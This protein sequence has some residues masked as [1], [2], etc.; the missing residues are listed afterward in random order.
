MIPISTLTRRFAPPSPSE[1]GKGL[2]AVPLPLGEGGAKRRVRVEVLYGILSGLL[3]TLSLPKPDFYPLAWIALVPWLYAILREPNRRPVAIFSWVAGFVFF[4]GTFYWMTE[5]MIIYGG[6]SYISAVGI[7]LLFAVVYSF[8]FLAF[9][10]GVHLAAR[11]FGPRGL[12]VAA[13]LWVTI[14]L[15]RTHFFFSGFPWMLSGYALVPYIGI[16]QIVT[17]TGIYGLSFIATAVNSAVA[18][19]ILQRNPRWL[20]ATAVA[21]AVMWFFPLVG[22]TPSGDPIPVRIVQ[23]NISL[24]QPWVQPESNQLLD[25]LGTLSTSDQSKPRLVVWPETPAPFYLNDDADFR[26]RMQAI[27]RKLGAYFLVGYIGMLGEDPSNSAGLLN[28]EGNVVS[29]Y[30]KMHLVPFGEYIPLKKLLFFAESFTKQ[31]GNFAP[32]T[33]YT[34]S[35]LDGHRISTAICYESIFPDLM[36]QFV[37]QGSELFVLITND[38]WFGESSAPFQHL[39]M[40]VVRAVENRRYMVRDAN[41][42]IS[43]IIDPYGRIES[44]TRI[45]VRAILDGTA[46]FRSDLTFYTRYGDVFAYANALVASLAIAMAAKENHHARRTH[47]KVRS[48]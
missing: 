28:P 30:N 15:I 20:A 8:C 7:G 44:S 38:G 10:L 21:V 3:L 35:P 48:T 42:G 25:E 5:T 6:L 40:G 26:A 24:N 11:R 29:R 4:T 12:F 46:H 23:T 43:A 22:E 9:G 19:G 27:A 45:G 41:T 32:G 18:Y 16:L 37:K 14:E 47:R 2:K 31:V 33:E 36:R 34:I 39:R 17:W 1:R 13:P